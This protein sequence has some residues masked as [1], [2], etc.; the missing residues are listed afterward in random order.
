M[1]AMEDTALAE[2]F[3]ERLSAISE[4]INYHGTS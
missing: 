1:E 2:D 4:T 3:Y